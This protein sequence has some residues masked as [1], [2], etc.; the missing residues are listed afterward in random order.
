MATGCTD[1]TIIA[2]LHATA[3]DHASRLRHQPHAHA[4]A[5]AA[6]EAITL[7]PD[8]LAQASIAVA[9]DRQ[10]WTADAVV[11]LAAA[12]ADPHIVYRQVT[13]AATPAA[14]STR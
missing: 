9:R 3:V 4:A 2:A 1:H 5:V 14:T 6:I 11:L 12:G 8:L 10:W 7:R 13:D